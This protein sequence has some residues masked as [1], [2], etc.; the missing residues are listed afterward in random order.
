M[1][2]GGL[3][4]FVYLAAVGRFRRD[5]P[6]FRVLAA[7]IVAAS[8]VLVLAG[9][10]GM[11]YYAHGEW[12]TGLRTV[13]HSVSARSTGF[14]M[15]PVSELGIAGGAVLVVL[16][17]IGG[18]PGSA[19]GGIKVTTAIVL[20]AAILTPRHRRWEPE[21]QAA[22]A[23]LATSV[24]AIGLGIVLLWLAESA[25]LRGLFFESVSAFTTVGFSQTRIA[26]YSVAGKLVLITMMVLGRAMPMI[27]GLIVYRRASRPPDGTLMLG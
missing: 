10:I 16:M 23:V 22:I 20:G 27:V 14:V 4:F 17:L 15:A 12:A 3:G 26:S 19:A 9:T 7:V 24:F 11:A 13:F 5:L 8:L 2:A 18:A 21:L 6:G 1:I 25:P